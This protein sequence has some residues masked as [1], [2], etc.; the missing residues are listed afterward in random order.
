MVCVNT[1]CIVSSSVSS[2]KCVDVLEWKNKLIKLSFEQNSQL[3]SIEDSSF[4]EFKYLQK[5]DFSNCNQLPSISHCAFYLCSSLKE[6]IFPENGV[7]ESLYGGC[8]SYTNIE[9]IKLPKSLKYMYIL[10]L[11]LNYSLNKIQFF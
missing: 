9:T 8:F 10:L 2:I 6:I 4:K 11:V 5:V 1:D 7:L 3:V